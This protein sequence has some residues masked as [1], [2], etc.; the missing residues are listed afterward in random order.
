MR[1]AHHDFVVVFR[2]TAPMRCANH[3]AKTTATPSRGSQGL[4][5]SGWPRFHV[6][7]N[8]EKRT[9][10]F[11]ALV[12]FEF[13]TFDPRTSLRPALVRASR[14]RSATNRECSP[15]PA[16]GCLPALHEPRVAGSLPRC[17]PA[18]RS[19]LVLLRQAS[20]WVARQSYPAGDR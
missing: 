14:R 19:A 9:N 20:L 17:V 13:P 2:F 11:C 5:E 3:L 4:G 16:A 1:Q 18:D 8:N 10:A 15:I 6:T 12:L 7:S